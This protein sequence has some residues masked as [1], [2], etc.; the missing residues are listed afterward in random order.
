M[1]L[2][3]EVVLPVLLVF[4]TGFGLQ[5]W[6]RLHI[7]SVSTVALYVFVPCLVFRTIYE[8]DMDFRYF[9]MLVF[10][11]ALLIALITV[12]KITSLIK[13]YP[14]ETE[15]GMILSTA[16]M[17][18]GNYGVPV[19]LFAFGQHGF[20][21]AVMYFVLQAMIMYS[22]GVYYA[23]RGKAG[24]LSAIRSVFAMP[25]TY[26]FVVGLLVKGFHIPIPDSA[27]SVI[28]L[29]GSAAI[30]CVMVVLGMQLAEIEISGFR[31][32]KIT[33]ASI[34]RL[35]VSP[36]IAWV[37]TLIIP[38]DPMLAKVLIVLSAMPSAATTTMFAVQFKSEP[39]LVSS[40]T[41]VT[42]LLSVFT[43]T[44][45]LIMLH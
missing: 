45:I 7:Q 11:L 1:H 37:L 17:N 38:M 24:I 30:P 43:V 9:E 14:Q 31:W 2:F 19:V 27:F 18:S 10:A 35:V 4:L 28:D 15:S 34:L 16:F 32:G 42:T 44:G 13:K 40:I 8:K 29:V 20:S 5:K 39:R 22:F 25:A 23:A 3:I 36:L 33:Y 12:I 21:Y 26:A 41:L 6:K